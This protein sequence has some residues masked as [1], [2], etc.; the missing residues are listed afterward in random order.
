MMDNINKRNLATIAIYKS[1]FFPFWYI[2]FLKY[3]WN[4]QVSNDT[5]KP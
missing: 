3:L 4:V 5:G 2:I 1:G